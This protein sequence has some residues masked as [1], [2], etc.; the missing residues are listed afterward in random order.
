MYVVKLSNVHK[1]FG[2]K[3]VLNDISFE[4]KENEKVCIIG[5]NGSGKTTLLRVILGLVKPDNGAI[6]VFSR[7]PRDIG[8]LPQIPLQYPY[9]KVFDVIYYSL[10]FAGFS[11]LK[12]KEKAIEWIKRVG[13]DS[14]SV[15]LN[16][17]GGERKLVLLAMAMAKDPK[18]LI[19]DEPTNMID[20][21]KKKIVWNIIR[22]FK[23][24]IIIVTHDLDEIWLGDTI[25]FMKQ[26]RIVFKGNFNDFSNKIRKS[27]FIVESWSSEG[28]MRFEID[29]IKDMNFKLIN[30][31]IYELKIRKIVPE[32]IESL[33]V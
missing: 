30:E 12:A 20:I 24:T 1:T 25:Y 14:D 21:H 17:S 15:G 6:N 28:Y 23:G 19:L 3:K 11:S 4:I 8:Y 5:P 33:F 2:S 32:D 29:N 16:L 18:L 7:D 31:N 13:L 10:R 22:E 26:G 27:G 9:H